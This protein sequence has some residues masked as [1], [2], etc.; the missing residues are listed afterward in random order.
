VLSVTLSS[1]LLG[2]LGTWGIE[3]FKRVHGLSAT[4]AGAYAPAIG[5]GA[6]AGLLGGGVLADR[7]LGA[8]VRLAR[9]YVAAVASVAASVVL[10]PAVLTDSLPL[11]AV[12]LFV[13]STFLTLPVAPSEALLSD[14]VP[15]ALRG[16]AA[17]VRAIV[18]S[19]AALAPWIVGRLSDATD[20]QVALASVVPLYGIGG[21]V[22]LLAARTYP[23]DLAAAGRSSTGSA[24]HTGS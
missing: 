8:G 7:L 3:L 2:A 16:R 22:M 17:S 20:L 14:V 15:P 9:V 13:G 18:R 4:E 19:L 5:A 12:L 21:V 23:A 6:A 11:A 24:G 10:V 1:F